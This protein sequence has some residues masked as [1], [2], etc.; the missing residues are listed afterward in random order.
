[1]D[2]LLYMIKVLPIS[3]Q[4]SKWF[5]MLNYVNV[6][7]KVFLTIKTCYVTQHFTIHLLE[8]NTIQC[9]KL[10]KWVILK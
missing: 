1:M 8:T 2:L 7:V 9:F 4:I 6:Q 5:I 3:P 10:V